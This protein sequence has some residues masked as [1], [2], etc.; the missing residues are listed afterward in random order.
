MSPSPK[1]ARIRVALARE[2]LEPFALAD[3]AGLGSTLKSRL[4]LAGFAVSL[5]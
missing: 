1:N 3:L 2:R 4:G 5:A